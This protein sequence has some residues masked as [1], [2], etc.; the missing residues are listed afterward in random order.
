MNDTSTRT[1]WVLG[2]S[3]VILA[4]LAAFAMVGLPH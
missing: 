3:V 2:L 4:G 1:V